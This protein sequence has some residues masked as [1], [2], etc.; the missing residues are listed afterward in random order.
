[1]MTKNV[2]LVIVIAGSSFLLSACSIQEG[3][4]VF[5]KRE[6]PKVNTE[7]A[8]SVKDG[9]IIYKDT[10]KYDTSKIKPQKTSQNYIF[11]N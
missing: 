4:I 8:I 7:S 3:S 6:P 10:K 5:K 9:V 2:K 1:M 11:G